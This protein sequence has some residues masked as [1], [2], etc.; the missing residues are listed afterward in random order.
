[1]SGTAELAPGASLGEPGMLHFLV[2]A[3][4]GIGL[5]LR[6]VRGRT[7]GECE[8]PVTLEVDEAGFGPV[9]DL[10][11]DGSLA[12]P[13]RRTGVAEQSR[14]RGQPSR[15]RQNLVE[16]CLGWVEPGVPLD[17]VPGV[18]EQATAAA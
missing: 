6:C 4:L 15:G 7:A 2:L 12:Q 3:L 18:A 13:V 16:R 5:R 9:S 14:D 17:T 11:R 10:A 8:H 1:M